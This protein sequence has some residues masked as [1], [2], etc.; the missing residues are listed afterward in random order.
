V[1]SLKGHQAFAC[2]FGHADL[3]IIVQLDD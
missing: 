1:V 3:V 2:D